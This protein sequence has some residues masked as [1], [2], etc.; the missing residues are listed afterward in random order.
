MPAKFSGFAITEDCC[1]LLFIMKKYIVSKEKFNICNSHYLNQWLAF[2]LYGFDI[3][4]RQQ[5]C[6]NY[7][8]IFLPKST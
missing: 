3:A 5:E 8:V 7:C 1:V 4:V 2:I 6:L